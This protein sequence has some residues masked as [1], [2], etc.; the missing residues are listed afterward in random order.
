VKQCTVSVGGLPQN[1]FSNLNSS[2][3]SDFGNLAGGWK[4][5]EEDPQRLMKNNYQNTIVC[6]PIFGVGIG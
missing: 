6:W 4:A 5:I 2:S 1:T 3:F